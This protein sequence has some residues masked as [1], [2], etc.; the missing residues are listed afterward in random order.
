ML[1][2]VRKF[3]ICGTVF[4]DFAVNYW[5]DR[6]MPKE[7]LIM[8]LPFYGRMYTLENTT[9]NEI[10]SPVSEVGNPGHLNGNDEE[11]GFNEVII[12]SFVSLK[13]NNLY[14]TYFTSI[15]FKRQSLVN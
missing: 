3:G 5:L 4:Q 14:F 7:K 2:H 9:D 6:G 12:F 15:S 13:C 1:Y 11:L 10:G 8:A